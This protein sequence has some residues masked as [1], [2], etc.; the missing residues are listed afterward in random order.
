MTF[1]GH[2]DVLR[3]ILIRILAVTLIFACLIFAF[4]DV[5]FSVLLSPSEPDFCTYRWLEDLIRTFKPEF[6]FGAFH[7]DLIATD[8]S[9]QFM[10]H[11]TTSVYLGLFCSSPFIL[12]EL[13]KFVS[14]ALLDNEKKYSVQIVCIIYLLFIIGIFMSYFVLFPI[15]F[16]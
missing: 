8:L 3:K 2:L 12:Y 5:T 1:G 6:S 11:I 14:P 16:R 13:F 9:S 10:T 4:K 15:S 7:I